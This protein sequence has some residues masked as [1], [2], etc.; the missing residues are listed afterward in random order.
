MRNSLRCGLRAVAPRGDSMAS[1]HFENA[2]QTIGSPWKLLCESVVTCPVLSFRTGGHPRTRSRP[3]ATEPSRRILPE[4]RTICN[5][6]VIDWAD[7]L[8]PPTSRRPGSTGASTLTCCARTCFRGT[9][10]ASSRTPLGTA[11][12]AILEGRA[13]HDPPSTRGSASRTGHASQH[14]MPCCP[15]ARTFC[16]ATSLPAH[17][18]APSG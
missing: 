9:C 2:L 13:D 6:V 18:A 12:S 17:V 16:T 1:P 11:G 8:G 15:S 4:D 14:G 7:F 5:A 10:P 3:S